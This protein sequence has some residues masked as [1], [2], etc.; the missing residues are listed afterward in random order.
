MKITLN[1]RPSEIDAGTTLFGLHDTVK[2]EADIIIINGAAVSED[3]ALAEGD[4]VCLIQRGATPSKDELE[5]LIA[6]RHT[7]GVH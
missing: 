2:P 3:T 6:A 4:Q 7:P 1:E 5:A